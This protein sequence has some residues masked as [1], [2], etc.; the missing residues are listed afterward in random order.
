MRTLF[1]TSYKFDIN[2]LVDPGERFRVLALLAFALLLPVFLSG[3]QLTEMTLFFCYALAGIG[4]MVLTG[5]T[6][7]VSFGHAA[8]LAL[9][10][11]GHVSFLELGVPFLILLPLGGLV[12]AAVG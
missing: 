11:Y 2:H 1:K 3:Y 4:L 8:F 5:F 12:A 9:G 10:A 7:R 6:G